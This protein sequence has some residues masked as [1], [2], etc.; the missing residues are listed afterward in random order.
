MLQ[1]PETAR[2]GEEFSV[3]VSFNNP[4]SETLTDCSIS[5]E[6]GGFRHQ[7][8]I[9]QDE[10]VYILFALRKHICGFQ[11]QAIQPQRINR[12]LKGICIISRRDKVRI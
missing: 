2:K 7:S 1:M 11:K 9:T 10:Y 4:L 8:A 5:Y 3:V 6:G 12:G